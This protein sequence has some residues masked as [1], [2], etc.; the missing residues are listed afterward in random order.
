MSIA[1]TS[2]VVEA[3]T[4]AGEIAR[5]AN[6]RAEFDRNSDWLQANVSEIYKQHRGKFICV[7]G[8]QVFVADSVADAIAQARQAHPDESGWFTRYIPVEKVTRVYAS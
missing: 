6:Q 1:Q 3:V 2:V 8:R 4:D 5:A 7:A